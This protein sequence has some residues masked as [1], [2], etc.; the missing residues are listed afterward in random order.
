MAAMILGLLLLLHNQPLLPL[1]PDLPVE[2]VLLKFNLHN[3]LENQFTSFIL[4]SALL[5]NMS[6]VQ[7]LQRMRAC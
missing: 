1:P 7:S 5:Q 2:P 3:C 6:K 4:T